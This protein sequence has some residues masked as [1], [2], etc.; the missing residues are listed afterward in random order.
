MYG[1]SLSYYI[2]VRSG[3]KGQRDFEHCQELRLKCSTLRLPRIVRDQQG[4]SYLVLVHMLMLAF[5]QVS[6]TYLPVYKLEGV[7]MVSLNSLIDQHEA[8][9]E[10][11]GQTSD[12]W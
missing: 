8:I 3:E 6:P 5:R 12:I 7:S 11:L 9:L 10:S 2:G 1:P 4:D